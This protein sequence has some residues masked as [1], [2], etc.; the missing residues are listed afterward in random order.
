MSLLTVSSKAT[1][2]ADICT[3]D[4]LDYSQ[5]LN[6]KNKKTQIHILYWSQNLIKSP[7]P[8]NMP[9]IATTTGSD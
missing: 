8:P 4:L 2:T 5:I 7:S 3:S 1:I 6:E 9:N